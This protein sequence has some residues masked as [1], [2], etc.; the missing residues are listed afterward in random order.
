MENRF[1]KVILHASEKADETWVNPD[2]IVSVTPD[3]QN[4]FMVVVLDVVDFRGWSWSP[5]I[6]RITFA[7]GRELL[8]I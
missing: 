2:H 4:R 3:P 7:S 6:Y 1:K 8:G 5:K